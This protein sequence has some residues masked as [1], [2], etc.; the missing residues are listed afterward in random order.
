MNCIN[1]IHFLNLGNRDDL[2]LSR[3]SAFTTVLELEHLLDWL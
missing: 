2:I 1:N 3:K